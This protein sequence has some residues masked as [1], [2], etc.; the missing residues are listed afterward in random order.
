M[1]WLLLALWS[2]GIWTGKVK[3]AAIRL[4][5]LSSMGMQLL[6]LHLDGLFTWEA[7]LPLHLCSLFGCLL[8]FFLHISPPV[9][10]EAVCFLGA[11]GALLTLFFPAVISCS[12][13]VLMRLAFYQL[14]VL[15]SLAPLYWYACKKP[16]PNDPRRTLIWGSGYLVC[17]SWFNRT[18]GTNYLFLRFAPDDTPLEW[19]ASSGTLFYLCAM[20]LLCM[21][22]FSFLKPF[23]AY[24]RT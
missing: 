21:L 24:L 7:V 22:V 3:A 17:I 5:L 2:Y 15:V 23:Y 8:L 10:V 11:P 13:P 16:L 19:L 18:F 20:E 4:G 12:Y 14:H 6:L 9:L 1:Q